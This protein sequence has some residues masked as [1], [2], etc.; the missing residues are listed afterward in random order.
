MMS[1]KSTR[2]Q[3]LT[4]SGAAAVGVSLASQLVLPRG[5]YAANGDETIRI[6]LVGCGGR[7]TGAASQA[8]STEGDVKL[9]A[10]ADAFEDQLN[11]TLGRLKKQKPDRVAVDEDHKF[12]GLDAYKKLIDSDVDLV[13]L[14]TPPGFRPVHVA[15]AVAQGKHV[16]MEKPVAIDAR[17]V[18]TVLAAVEEAK[19]KNLKVGVGLQRHHQNTYRAALEQVRDGAIGDIIAARVYWNSAGVWEPRRT[20]EQVSGEMEYQVRNWYYYNWLCGDHI[21]EQ[22]IHNIDVGCWFKD[23]YPVRAYGMGGREVR[24]APRYGNIFDHFA[25]EYEWADGSRMFSQCRHI[26]NCWN[27]VSEYLHG[28]KGQINL[29]GNPSYKNSDGNEWRY[30]GP[31]NDPY[32]TEH[33]DLFAAIREGKPYNEGEYGAFST[34]AAILGRMATYSGQVIEWD[35]ALNE[36][37]EVYPWDQEELTFDSKPPVLPGP[38]GSYAQP[39]PGITEVL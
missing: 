26:P 29:S 35:K 18:R 31:K 15:Y 4:R 34:M 38:D 5:A 17:G 13:I 6:G 22:H 25:V 32:Q 7:G 2:R 20:H 33:D 36:G 9:V 27:S 12:F 10:M 1:E 11:G 30:K 14:A 8:L 3:F 39:I 19:K 24:D 21:N 16:F 28:T 37:R 23:A